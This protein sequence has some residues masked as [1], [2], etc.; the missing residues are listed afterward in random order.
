MSYIRYYFNNHLVSV[1]ELVVTLKN[2][3]NIAST[4]TVTVP[5][6]SI[7]DTWRKCYVV[8]DGGK[9]YRYGCEIEKAAEDEYELHP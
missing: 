6:H 5:I 1:G 2:P 9:Q 8:I 4:Q 7:D 3:W